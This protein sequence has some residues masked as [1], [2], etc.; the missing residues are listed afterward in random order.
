MRKSGGRSATRRSKHVCLFGF[1]IGWAFFWAA[2]YG[3]T[4]LT[5]AGRS[6]G[7]ESELSLFCFWSLRCMWFTRIELRAQSLRSLKERSKARRL[8]AKFGRDPGADRRSGGNAR[9]S[10]EQVDRKFSRA[11]CSCN[12]NGRG[13]PGTLAKRC[14]RGWALFGV[15]QRQAGGQSP[16]KKACRFCSRVDEG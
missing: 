3:L 2:R 10:K 6:N 15:T 7:D 5:R 11:R 13:E 1:A 12:G 4:F 8:E 9:R 14:R 16:D